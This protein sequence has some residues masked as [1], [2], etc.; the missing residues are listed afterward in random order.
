[1]G[2]LV[3]RGIGHLKNA[4]PLQSVQELYGTCYFTVIRATWR[5]PV[6]RHLNA[7]LSPRLSQLSTSAK[8]LFQGKPALFASDNPK[9]GIVYTPG[10]GFWI[11]VGEIGWMVCRSGKSEDA[12]ATSHSARLRRNR[13]TSQTAKMS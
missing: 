7:F 8:I 1:M 12:Q 9:A 6:T 3:I 11:A 5:E 2:N 13:A 4:G 10:T